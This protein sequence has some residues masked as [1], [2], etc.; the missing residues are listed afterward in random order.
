MNSCLFFFSFIGHI[1]TFFQICHYWVFVLNFHVTFL[2]FTTNTALYFDRNSREFWNGFSQGP[3]EKVT[4]R[5]KFSPHWELKDVART[6][7]CKCEHNPLEWVCTFP[8]SFEIATTHEKKKKTR[9]WSRII[10][11]LLWHEWRPPGLRCRFASIQ[12]PLRFGI[13]FVTTLFRL[14]R[15]IFMQVKQCMSCHRCPTKS[16]SDTTPPLLKL[17][18]NQLLMLTDIF[19]TSVKAILAPMLPN[20]DFEAMTCFYLTLVF[21]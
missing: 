3:S 8:R 15:R 10:I 1:S 7:L 6:E 12:V 20:N 16:P 11:S 2:L 9:K 14:W 21:S 17:L 4:A 19:M 13:Y 5:Y 18:L